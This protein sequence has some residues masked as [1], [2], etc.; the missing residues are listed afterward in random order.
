M[1]QVQ[2]KIDWFARP[3]MPFC[4]LWCLIPCWFR[5]VS[6]PRSSYPFPLSV[7]N[8]LS[9]LPD[10][11]SAITWNCLNTFKTSDSGF[12]L[13]KYTKL[14]RDLSSINTILHRL[15]PRE[16]TST[17]PHWSEWT[18][19]CFSATRK[20]YLLN[21]FRHCLPLGQTLQFPWL[22]HTSLTRPAA[23]AHAL[24]DLVAHLQC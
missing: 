1:H 22:P 20:P 23:M 5:Y 10:W 17:G 2:S 16:L 15:P 14:R 8:I 13:R 11:S 18:M 3:V 6:K 19:S 7:L 24:D 4:V 9:F 21:R 12:D